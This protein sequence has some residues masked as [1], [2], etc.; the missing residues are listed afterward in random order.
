MKR[1]LHILVLL[2]LTVSVTSADAQRRRKKKEKKPGYEDERRITELFFDASKQKMLG[3]Y[4]E[5]AAL[6][7]DCIKIDTRNA[8][9]Y[10]ELANLFTI[11]QKLEEGLPFALR[12]LE[13][14]PKNQWYALFAAEIQLGLNDF[15]SAIKIYEKLT[16]QFPDQVDFQYELATTY[17]YLN[18]LE[19]AISAYNKIEEVIGVNEEISVQKEKIYLQM[20]RL[21]DAVRE[22]ENLIQNFPGEQRYLGMLA[23]VYTANDLLD[24]AFEVYE[25]MMEND[26]EDPI[27][28]LNLAEFYKKKGEFDA[29]YKE[30]KVAFASAALS[31]DSKIQVM[32]SYYSIS[33]GNEELTTQA[34]V[35]LELLTETHPADAKAFAM[36]ADFLL[37]DGDLNGS[38]NAF[39]ET[40][41]LDSSR[42][43]VWNQLVNT[44]YELKDY[45]AMAEDS[46]T[47]L[48]LF[49]NQGMMYLLNGIANN[50]LENY[51]RAAEVLEEGEIYT[52]SDTYMNVQLLSVLADVYNNLEQ[53]EKSDVAFEKAI[54]KDPNNAL[55]LNNY[56]YFL[57]LRAENL[58]RAE[59]LSKKSNLL[60]PRQ[61]SYQDTYAWILFQQKKYAEAKEWIE[62][63]LANGGRKSGVI[64]EHYGD[65]LSKL[66]NT[67]EAMTQ[68]KLALDLGDHSDDLHQKIDGT[69]VP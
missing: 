38:R 45:S 6:Y 26:P 32:M 55:I 34:Y 57:S 31:I 67:A 68:W 23:E 53:F 10:Y 15:N 14:D 3:N 39:Y 1:I 59:E 12:A 20:D 22:L 19:E 63:A 64:V 7:H 35:L 11:N 8:A 42:F 21:D 2:S 40:V 66:G 37:R 58:E 9:S 29:S 62:K 27:L 33:E 49:P 5:A 51:S 60:R 50:N 46:K 44:S 56:S 4:E 13:L 61:A 25:R 69:K 30:L 65:I 16:E 48:E 43:M 52:R 47:A 24:K 28:H 36:K 54:S 17:L 18:R 41:K